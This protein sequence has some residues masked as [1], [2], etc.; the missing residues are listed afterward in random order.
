[1]WDLSAVSFRIASLSVIPFW[2][3]MVLAPRWRGTAR[4]VA[5]PL[6]AAVP[7]LVYA[8]LVGP[9]LAALAPALA[10]PEL[11]DIARLLGTPM[12]ATIAWAH[13]LALDLLAGR[14]IFLDAR[15]R[16]LPAWLTSPVLVLTLLF[17]PLGLAA[18]ALGLAAASSPVRELAR[19]VW[20]GHR[21]L[22]VTAVGS[23]AALAFSLVA[24]LFDARQILG[25]SAWAKPAKFAASI[26]LMAI[27]LA[28]IIGQMQD[29]R[30][31]LARAGSIIAVVAL[32][33]YVAILVQTIRGVPSHFNNAT[34]FDG[35]LFT[36]MGLAITILWVAEIYLAV[37]SFRQS[38]GTPARTWAIRLGLASAVLSGALAFLMPVPTPAQ[39]ASLAEHERPALVGAH[40]VGVPDGGP[41][42]PVTRWSTEGGDLRVPHFLGLHALQALPLA[43][44]ALARRRRAARLVIAFGTAWLGLVLVT[45]HQALRAQPLFAPDHLTIFEAAL[46]VAGAALI[47]LWPARV[48]SR[49]DALA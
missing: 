1:M 10:R 48:P 42:L 20:N 45:L 19:K 8:G 43:A 21:L 41:G 6:I 17:A 35:L 46:V 13:F 12:G 40:A 49:A 24:Q 9:R 18:Y 28:W 47:A 26:G 3:L 39:K 29:P 37:R 30:R 38:F 22:A 5:S 23:L 32:V 4:A 11:T 33:E 15:E 7:V 2:A 44:F 14:W 34:V 16:G 25:A 27:S 31:R 36:A